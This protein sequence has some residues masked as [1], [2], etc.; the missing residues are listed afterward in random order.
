METIA[1]QGYCLQCGNPNIETPEGAKC[2]PCSLKA[3]KRSHLTVDIEDPGEEA[4]KAVLNGAAIKATKAKVTV[5]A[6]TT[7][8]TVDDALAIVKSFPIPSDLKQFKKIKKVID[9]LESLKEETE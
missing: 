4:F 1:G 6:S 7:R 8:G 5:A 9:L 3:P 2:I